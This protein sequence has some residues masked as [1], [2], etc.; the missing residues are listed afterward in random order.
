[1]PDHVMDNLELSF[2][3]VCLFQIPLFCCVVHGGWSESTEFLEM[4]Q[5]MVLFIE[6]F[7]NSWGPYTRTVLHVM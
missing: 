1:M 4:W 5:K 3:N 2:S 6:S 7:Y